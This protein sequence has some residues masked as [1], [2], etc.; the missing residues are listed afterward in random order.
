[1]RHSVKILFLNLAALFFLL[2]GFAVSAQTDG[3]LPLKFNKTSHNFGK[4]SVND[5]QKK[6]TFEFT[7]T[8]AGPIV[9]NNIISSCG[10]TE[11]VWP[12][13]P[14]M[15]GESGKIE[16]TYLNDQGPYPFEK[17]LTVYTSASRKPILLR[18]SGI[19]YEKDKS[20]KEIFPVAI[21]P[22]GIMRNN[23]KL[24]QIEQG[25]VKSGS[26]S[27]ANLSNR[28]VSVKFENVSKGLF[29]KIEPATVKAGEIAEI[30]YT[31]NT[32]EQTNW[33]NTVYSASVI[34]NGVKAAEK[35]NINTMIIDK[36][37]GLTKEQ[38][39]SG[40]MILAK[41]SSV[42]LG[43]IDKGKTVEALFHL[44]NTGAGRLIIHKADNNGKNFTVSAPQ[45]VMP[46]EEFTVK[47]IIESSRFSGEQVFTITLVT[48]SPNRPL[49][50][51]FV[52]ANIN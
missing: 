8:S 3:S 11:P 13:K 41:N 50:N 39:N 23:I 18:I 6:C 35:L 27:V 30:S 51:L 46:G 22:L 7:N 43:N 40:S 24:G 10:C 52:A 42:S 5:G 19:V 25:Y 21:G 12:K 9:I 31:V 36:I 38:K 29:I 37:S 48:N 14:I 28:D 17:T 45:S 15:P 4:F 20:L 34:C 1:M 44:R 26:V 47:A 33:G 16:V 32:T 49:M 2:S